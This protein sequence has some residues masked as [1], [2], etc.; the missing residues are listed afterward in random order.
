L[1]FVFP[2][3]KSQ[4]ALLQKVDAQFERRTDGKLVFYPNKAQRYGYVIEPP[5]R[6]AAVR[7]YALRRKKFDPI[8]AVV[9]GVF[10]PLY[11][12]AIAPRYPWWLTS[13]IGL[14]GVA[15]VIVPDWLWRRRVTAGL[16]TTGEPTN[17][18]K[19]KVMAAVIG[20]VLI[21]VSIYRPAAN[22]SVTPGTIVFHPDIG[23][24]ILMILPRRGDGFSHR[25]SRGS[26]PD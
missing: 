22:P 16:A 12:Y 2:D 24:P 17:T 20:A 10:V 4:Q 26:V 14:A 15:C 25:P 23:A 13:A 19:L 9:Y 3:Q 5:E 8:L 18:R 11:F 21:F 1:S 7:N 6:E